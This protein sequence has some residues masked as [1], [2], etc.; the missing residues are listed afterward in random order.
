[1]KANE[2]NFNRF[3]SQSDTQF[4]IPVYQRNYDWA[5]PQCKQLLDDVL[6]IGENDKSQAHFIG[7]IV[8]VH[9]DVYS[10]SG[11][12]ELTVIDGQQRLTTITILYIVDEGRFFSPWGYPIVQTTA[13]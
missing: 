3:L 9:D 7:S 12:R 4:I 10:A 5:H 11:I 6:E 13:R 2:I 8:Y 1:M